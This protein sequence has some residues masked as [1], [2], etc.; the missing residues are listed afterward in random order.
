MISFLMHLVLSYVVLSGLGWGLD[1]VGLVD[2]WDFQTQLVL[3]G[4]A[5]VRAVWAVWS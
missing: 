4:I 1:F 3:L 5:V 2:L